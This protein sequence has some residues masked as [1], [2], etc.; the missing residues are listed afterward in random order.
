[1]LFR[2][3]VNLLMKSLSPDIEDYCSLS[4]KQQFVL[5]RK[6]EMESSESDIYI[7]CRDTKSIDATTKRFAEILSEKYPKGVVDVS[8]PPTLFEQIFTTGEAELEIELSKKSN[9]N[10]TTTEISS[11]KKGL[12]IG[13]IYL[14]LI[15][16]LPISIIS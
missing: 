15:F 3:R 12:R 2:S 13:A 7:K 10:I 5:K 11:L 1:M 8:P 14:F 9:S 16:L 4:G 6:R